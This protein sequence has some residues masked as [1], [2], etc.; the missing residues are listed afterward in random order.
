M[1]QLSKKLLLP[2]EWFELL[3]QY[4]F[5]CVY[6]ALLFFLK[7]GKE[8]SSI[9]FP[10]WVFCLQ[11]TAS[12]KAKDHF[13]STEVVSSS[14]MVLDDIAPLPV[15]PQL[16]KAQRALPLRI[17]TMFK[18]SG[19]HFFQFQGIVVQNKS[20]AIVF[21]SVIYIF[22]ILTLPVDSYFCRDTYEVCQSNSEIILFA[23]SWNINTDLDML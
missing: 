20:C 22:G 5:K 2:A 19:M 23:Y 16:Q 21:I 10:V 17:A 4:F 1:H 11:K 13:Y 15:V 7:I 12:L 8:I 14:A 3:L 6:H 9:V 18:N